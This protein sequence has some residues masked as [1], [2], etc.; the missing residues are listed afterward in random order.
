MQAMVEELQTSFER[1]QMDL[2]AA[3]IA[4]DVCYTYMPYTNVCTMHTYTP[5]CTP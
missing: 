4:L 3:H 2:H 1:L 5:L